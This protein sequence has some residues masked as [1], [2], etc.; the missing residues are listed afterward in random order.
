MSKKSLWNLLSETEDELTHSIVIPPIQRDYAQGRIGKEFIRRS[1]LTEIKKHLD[2]HQELTLDFVYGGTESNAFQP[3]D[4]QQRLTTLWLVHWYIALCSGRL[5]DDIVRKTLDRFSYETRTSSR[6]FC[7]SL[8]N[9]MMS[10]AN[11]SSLID[12]IK[13]QSWFYASWMQDPTINAMLRTIG[14]EDDTMNDSIVAVFAN[15]ALNEFSDYWESLTSKNIVTFEIMHIG[16]DKLPITDDLYIKMNARGKPLSDF[17]NLKA[18]LVSWIQSEDNPEHQRYKENVSF[19]E[20]DKVSYN[21]YYPAQLDTSWTDVFWDS[22][23]T[24]WQIIGK[25]FDG[26]IDKTFFSFINRYVLNEICLKKGVSDY[27][28]A[29]TF[30]PEKGTEVKPEKELFDRLYGVSVDGLAAD[31]SAVSYEEFDAYKLL[32]FDK[33]RELDTIFTAL[34]SPDIKDA[35]TKSL[36]LDDVDGEDSDEN[37]NTTYSFIPKFVKPKRGDI[38]LAATK[39][40]ERVY[41]LAVC[42]FL[43]SCEFDSIKFSQWMR[44]IRNITENAAINNIES[45]VNCLRLVS[46]LSDHCAKSEW[47]V[48]HAICTFPV[49]LDKGALKEQLIEEKEKAEQII[50]NPYII[51][52]IYEAESYAFFNGTIRFL[53]RNQN[54]IPEWKDF[55]TK[56]NNA[57]DLFDDERNVK[58]NTI[59]S[60]LR[61]FCGF[62][63]IWGKYYFTTIGYHPR[64]QCWKRNILCDQG[65]CDKIHLLLSNTINTQIRGK[66]YQRFIDSGLIDYICHKDENDRYRYHEY[67]GYVI[68]KERSQNEGVYI[69]NARTELLSA[70]KTFVDNKEIELISCNEQFGTLWWGIDIRFKYQGQLY[71]LFGE[72]L[73]YKMVDNQYS[74]SKYEW[75]AG[76]N[77]L[78]EVSRIQG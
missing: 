22:G 7:H 15:L 46:D 71:S 26:S 39:Q 74:K 65:L 73:F 17:E 20:G 50:K 58:P 31:D 36:S 3:L 37:S 56:F 60:F 49:S 59:I 18:D 6:D 66:D 70:M 57:K 63:E 40:K 32:S 77:I 76:D 4:G 53:Y 21:I 52:I 64:K 29:S 30:D 23:K 24:N 45:M 42:K 28:P 8:C 9:K 10:W 38:R 2:S 13:N 55:E 19:Y 75:K 14:G 62:E 69:S 16:N 12:Y 34:Q 47:N 44:I 25:D 78:Q 54:G 5:K 51:D 68:H 1:F 61:L 72:N 33:L 48:Y 67:Y 35:I 11:D 43:S 27:L 41:F